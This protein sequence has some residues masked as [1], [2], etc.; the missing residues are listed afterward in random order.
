MDSPLTGPEAGAEDQE[1]STEEMRKF[2]A[3]CPVCGETA[4][5]TWERHEDQSGSESKEKWRLA[6]LECL[7][8]GCPRSRYS[9]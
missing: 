1:F 7:T 6:S 3:D 4:Y 8:P 5:P 2:S 9:A